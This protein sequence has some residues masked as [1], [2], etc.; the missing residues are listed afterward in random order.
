MG[1]LAFFSRPR[2]VLELLPRMRSILSTALRSDVTTS[3]E[4][5]QAVFTSTVHHLFEQ[6]RTAC[7]VNLLLASL[8]MPMLWSEA[9]PA[10][11]AAWG[12]GLIAV[13]IAR[14][15]LAHIYHQTTNPDPHIWARR[16]IVGLA[17]SSAFWGLAV[18]LFFPLVSP[19]K[20]LALALSTGGIAAGALPLNAA[21]LAFYLIHVGVTLI[22]PFALF[23]VWG[24]PI[25]ILLALMT[26]IFGGSL[27]VAG[28][29]Y[30]RNLHEAHQFAAR[31]DNANRAL[32]QQ[33]QIHTRFYDNM[34]IP[35]YR[36]TGDRTGRFVRFNAAFMRLLEADR[37][38]Q[39]LDCN[40][41]D[42]YVDPNERA[43]F[44]GELTRAGEVHAYELQLRTLT[45]RIIQCIDTAYRLEDEHGRVVF[46]GALE[47]VTRQR[48]LESELAYQ[49]RYDEL[50][51]LANRR[52]CDMLLTD[53][54][55]GCERD[56]QPLSLLMLDLD[57]FKRVNDEHGHAAGDA[58]LQ[59]VAG[60]IQENV[61]KTDT[62][63]RWGGEEFFV[64][65]PSTAEAGAAELA[66]KLR[67]AVGAIT[68]TPGTGVTVSI[69]YGEY[70]ASEGRDALLARVDE[71]LY[72]AKEAGRDCVCS[73]RG[74]G[75]VRAP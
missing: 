68:H 17:A 62:A 11:V 30:S 40:I 53:G 63:G 26:L 4:V 64:L 25:H 43:G 13:N 33:L 18:P 69:G 14:L 34:P 5:R 23:L 32:E 15:V 54:I 57:H 37:P 12:G 47:D 61:R 6:I 7:G 55:A 51:N 75:P 24:T 58:L 46:D 41:T 8:I 44:C 70:V 48:E 35:L 38:E 45:G 65:L 56:G 73:H 42:L 74:D 1:R 52:H 29:S 50:T 16:Y 20:G 39:L 21:I 2:K 3:P 28:R 66:E 67:H 36:A 31:L 10:W 59:R 72:K 19:M 22:P 71:A 49:A 27:V 60:I 9:P